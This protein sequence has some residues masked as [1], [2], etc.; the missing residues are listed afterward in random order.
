MAAL[1][2]GDGSHVYPDKLIRCD[3][4]LPSIDVG[5]LEQ[6]VNCGE[7]RAFIE[8]RIRTTAGQ[9]GISGADLKAM[10]VPICGIEEQIRIRE[11]LDTQL[12]GI[13]ATE[14]EITT[15]LTK[16]SALRQSI[17][18]KAFTGELVPQD[19]AD[20]PAATLLA[21]I[22]AEALATGPQR[23]KNSVTKRTEKA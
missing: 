21:R 22:R 20:E 13:E 2:R 14:T 15:A 7:A 9:A 5:F 16:I 23:K 12:S 3:L 11:T 6:A 18:K 17:L 8:S 10:P 19:P 4:R 1:Y